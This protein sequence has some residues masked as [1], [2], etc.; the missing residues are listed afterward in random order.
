M[1]RLPY[2]EPSASLELAELYSDIAGLRGSVHNLQRALGN[3]PAALSAFMA[4]SRYIRGGSSLPPQLR[5][6]AV[7]VVAHAQNV[8]YEIFYHVPAARRAGVPD[9]QLAAFPDWV[10]SDRFSPIERAVMSY[11]NQVARQLDVDDATFERLRAHLSMPEVVDLA[12]TVGWYC[13]CSAIIVPLRIEPD[14]N[15]L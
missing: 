5:E 6:L 13:L 14:S 7:L 4:M 9:E 11:A 1:A 15:C 10:A 8:Q 12:L 3:N 2:P